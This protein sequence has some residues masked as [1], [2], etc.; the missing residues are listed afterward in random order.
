MALSLRKLENLLGNKGLLLKRYFT[1]G[2]MCVYIEV[3]VIENA[4]IFFLYIPS[5]YDIKA[6]DGP[7]TF[8]LVPIE[9]N[10]DGTIAGD[11]AGELDNAELEKRYEE[12][13]VDLNPDVRSR[14]NLEDQLEGNYNYPLSLKDVSKKDMKQLREVFRQLKRLRLCVQS[15]KYKLCITFNNYLCCI[16]RDDTFEGFTIGGPS[17]GE[18]RK[19]FVSIDLE[20]LYTKVSTLSA[21]VKTVREGV[22]RVLDKNQVKH[23][24]DLQKIL[25]HKAD[26]VSSS[27][28]IS[29]RKAKYN[30]Y[31]KELEKLLEK[32]RKTEQRTI[33][34]IMRVKERYGSEASI[35]GLHTDIERSHIVAKYEQRITSINIVKQDVVGN[36]LIVKGRLEDL[37]LKVD[38]VCF[39]NIVMLDA[40]LRNFVDMTEF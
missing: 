40:I 29:K 25:E 36:I 14:E 12:V 22:Y 19:L 27:E 23:T 20:A 11:Y 39:D 10:E 2:G 35:K 24:R 30:I 32:L 34:E 5:K 18:E 38:K 4:D 9:V 16:R 31:L 8:K 33:E 15:L 7:S 1:I 37:A 26:F 3:L 6:P 21:D 17:G 28:L 13:D